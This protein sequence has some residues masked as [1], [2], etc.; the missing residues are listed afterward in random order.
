ML[1]SNFRWYNLREVCIKKRGG[2]I[3]VINNIELVLPND[4]QIGIES[5]VSESNIT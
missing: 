3:M 2:N 4:I 5:I 1:N